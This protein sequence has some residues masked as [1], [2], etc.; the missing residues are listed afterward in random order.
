MVEFAKFKTNF[1]QATQYFKTVFT[2]NFKDSTSHNEVSTS[3][4]APNS[5]DNEGD[6]CD[7][8]QQNIDVPYQYTNSNL[9][10][11]LNSDKQSQAKVN[12]HICLICGK[13]FKFKLGLQ[14]HKD[15]VHKTNLWQKKK[16]KKPAD[17]SIIAS[18]KLDIVD[19]GSSGNSSQKLCKI[20][21]QNFL[22]DEFDMHFETH[23]IYVCKTCGHR[24]IRKTDLNDH[25][26]IH[27]NIC[28][29][30]CQHCGKAFKVRTA[31][32]KVRMYRFY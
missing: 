16:I 12:Q 8:D 28:K 4:V 5:S 21:K 3:I 19:K 31:L 20:C 9:S 7:D 17:N 29:Y 23:K 18:V 32:N 26:E 1:Q 25:E 15:T 22:S 13:D 14:R 24:F 11:A 6:C 2:Q 27:S 10:M 30:V